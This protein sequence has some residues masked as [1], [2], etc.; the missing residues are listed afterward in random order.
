LYF[1][2]GLTNATNL[3]FTVLGAYPVDIN[4]IYEV[5]GPPALTYVDNQFI[6]G[7]GSISEQACANVSCTVT[8]LALATNNTPGFELVGSFTSTGTFYINKDVNDGGGTNNGFSEF[9]DSTA[10]APEP[11]SLV[12]LG[13]GLLG[14]A[15]LLFRRNRAR[16]GSVA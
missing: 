7:Q 4:L 10:Y 13:T 6:G 14:A 15:F 3:A 16:S 9:N 2:A 1:N 11:S 8:L 12:L 5:Q